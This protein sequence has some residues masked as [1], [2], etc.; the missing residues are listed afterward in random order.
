V[1]LVGGSFEL[2]AGGTDDNYADATAGAGGVVGVAGASAKTR[3]TSHTTA[4]I[5][6]NLAVAAASDVD[7]LDISADH[8]ARYNAKVDA[9]GAGAVGISAARADNEVNAWVNAN[10][11]DNVVI[12]ANDISIEA[13]NRS[14]KASLGSDVFNASAGAGGALAGAASRSESDIWNDTGLSIGDGVQLTVAGDPFSPDGNLSLTAA[15][16]VF[17]RDKAKLDSGGAI[18]LAKA[19]SFV[20]APQ[21]DAR[22]QIGDADLVSVGDI[23]I[24]ALSSADIE[25]RA[26]S[27]TYGLAGAAQGE[28]RALFTAANQVLVKDGSFF[29]AEGDI[30][31]MSGR[32]LDGGT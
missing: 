15:N 11:G 18:A 28:S 22:V 20:R 10:V 1:T 6:D 21:N 12:T 31:L 16:D 5:K 25:A 32:D 29:R 26:N 17:A 9:T 23:N 3:N 24:A 8:L 14:E 13:L 4:E 30:N 27:K 19:E 7:L 2:F